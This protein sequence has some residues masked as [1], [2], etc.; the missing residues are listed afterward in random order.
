MFCVYWFSFRRKLGA[1]RF[2]H[3]CSL[4]L[5]ESKSSPEE[6]RA[7]ALPPFFRLDCGK[8]N[9][10]YLHDELFDFGHSLPIWQY[11]MRLAC[12]LPVGQR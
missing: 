4:S 2:R 5:D 11:S 12:G 1:Y 8:R 9:E 6:K 3:C 10:M 7:K